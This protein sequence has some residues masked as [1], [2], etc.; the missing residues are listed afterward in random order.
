MDWHRKHTKR[1]KNFGIVTDRLH[2]PNLIAFYLET[3]FK[4]S[5]DVSEGGWTP[6]PSLIFSMKRGNCSQHAAFATYCLRKAGYPAKTVLFAGF[7][8]GD[9]GQ[10]ASE[11]KDKDGKL[12]VMDATLRGFHGINVITPKEDYVKILPEIRVLD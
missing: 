5:K 6:S 7:Y 1:W 9:R 11:F 2:S 8:I 4:Y 10:T 3:H 12:Y